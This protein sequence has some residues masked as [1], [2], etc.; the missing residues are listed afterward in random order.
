VR[1]VV[2]WL[3]TL[4]FAAAGTLF[5]HA[6]AYRLAG[7]PLGPTHAYLEHA[8]QVLLVLATLV[9][10]S[11]AFTRAATSP[12]AWPFPLVALGAF[13]A[14]EHLERLVHTGQF[15]WL[16]TQPVFLVGLGLQLPVALVAWALARRL[17][18]TFGAPSTVRLRLLPRLQL[19]V[20]VPGGH[21]RAGR[22]PKAPHAR[23]PP[24][25]LQPC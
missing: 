6:L 20:A 18:G 19:T 2:A 12:P 5:A 3:F 10:C 11:L 16:L 8:P 7:E 21:A 9:A 15:P 24:A 25:P 13:V 22:R 14:Q 23:G 17:L 1:H 4:V